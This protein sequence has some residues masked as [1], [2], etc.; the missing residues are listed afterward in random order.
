MSALRL[1][2]FTVAE[3]PVVEPWFDDVETRR[4]LGDHRW[5][6]VERIVSSTR[7]NCLRANNSY[8]YFAATGALPKMSEAGSPTWR[9]AS[10]SVANRMASL[11]GRRKE[12]G[13]IGNRKPHSV[14]SI[15]APRSHT[16]RPPFGGDL[17]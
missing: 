7:R 1:V 4:W 8:L 2:P 12:L 5:A 13:V 11:R 16:Q 17:H 9:A 3:L 10:H 15:G 14:S 6:L